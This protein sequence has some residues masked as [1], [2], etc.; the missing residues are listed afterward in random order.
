MTRTMVVVVAVVVAAG[1]VAY[2]RH[3]RAHAVSVQQHRLL[4]ARNLADPVGSPAGAT[5]YNPPLQFTCAFYAAAELCF[6]PQHRLVETVVKNGPI[7]TLRWDHSAS[8]WTMPAA[9]WRRV[10]PKP[11]E[12]SYYP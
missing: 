10:F 12:S 4:A 9:L 5:I 7:G 2:G 3:E 1:V 8:P 11:P 6:D